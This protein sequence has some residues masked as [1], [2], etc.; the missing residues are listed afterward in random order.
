MNFA[1]SN[2]AAKQQS[3]RNSSRHKRKTR[4]TGR[5]NQ[6]GRLNKASP[7]SGRGVPRLR[8][9]RFLDSRGAIIHGGAYR[10]FHFGSS[11][12]HAVGNAGHGIRSRKVLYKRFHVAIELRHAQGNSVLEILGR[13]RHELFGKCAHDVKSG[14]WLLDA[15]ERFKRFSHRSLRCL[16]L[17]LNQVAPCLQIVHHR[18]E[19]FLSGGGGEFLSARLDGFLGGFERFVGQHGIPLK[20]V[21][22]QQLS[23]G[24]GWVRV[25]KAEFSVISGDAL[26]LGREVSIND[27]S[28][29]ALVAF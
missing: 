7:V 13:H 26:Q 27:P 19:R 1:S 12:F 4:R 24:N 16:G 5:V 17:L 6:W 23:F 22:V 3:C 29:N 10:A 8:S 15:F 28:T 18:L 20:N 21:A 11:I 14:L 25:R 2:S 9:A